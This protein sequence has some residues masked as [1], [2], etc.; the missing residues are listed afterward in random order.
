[1]KKYLINEMF[2]SLF[3]KVFKNTK[4]INHEKK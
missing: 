1:M 2:L 3:V 4:E